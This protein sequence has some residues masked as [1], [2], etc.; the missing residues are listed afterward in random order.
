MSRFY[1][2]FMLQVPAETH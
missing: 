1:G 2:L